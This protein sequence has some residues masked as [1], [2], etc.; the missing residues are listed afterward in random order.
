MVSLV[1]FGMLLASVVFYGVPVC[2]TSFLGCCV[3]C[4]QKEVAGQKNSCTLKMVQ[5]LVF[6][7]FQILGFPFDKYAIKML[8]LSDMH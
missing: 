5:F 6:L 1:R 4:Q 2:P 7:Y 3:I 8:N